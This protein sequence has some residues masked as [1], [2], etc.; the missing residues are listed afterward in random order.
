MYKKTIEGKS[1]LAAAGAFIAAFAMVACLGLAGC[2][3]GSSASSEESSAESSAAADAQE[4]IA[5]TV[6]VG[7]NESDGVQAATETVVVPVGASVTDALNGT[8][9]TIVSENGEYGT[10][11]TSINGVDATDT[12]AWVYTV[13]GEQATVGA[14]EYV[15][16][17][18]D[19]VEWTLTTF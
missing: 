4:D 1:K 12:T 8:T 7:G 18:G 3:S 10:F 13:N 17:D 11:V 9:Y 5:V 15:L 2:S 19:V 16:N 6:N 14:D